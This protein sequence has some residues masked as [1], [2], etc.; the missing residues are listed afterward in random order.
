M[1]PAAVAD[2]TSAPPAT[3]TEWWRWSLLGA[4]VAYLVLLFV[5]W[6]Y[7]HWAY[8]ERSSVLHGWWRVLMA[9]GNVEWR[10]CLLVPF[11]AG[12][13]V[14]RSRA[15]LRSLPAEGSW[16]GA[17]V[18]VFAVFCYWFGYK[19]DTGYLGFAAL[20]ASVAGLILLLGGRAWMRAL[21]LPWAFLVFAWPFFPMDNLLAAR[22]KIPTAQIAA[23]ILALT[24]VD[25]VREGST[26]VSAADPGN[27]LALGQ[28][29][30]L[31]VSD[32]CSGMRSLY[33]L[34]MTGALFAILSLRD[35]WPRLILAV[36]T[37]PLAILGNVVRL[38]LLAYGSLLFGQEFAVGKQVDGR[39]VDSAFHMLAGFLLFGVALAGMFGLSALLEGRRR[40]KKKARVSGSGS[41]ASS[42]AAGPV[43]GSPVLRSALTVAAAVVAISLCWA[44]PTA[45]TLAEPGLRI[46][47]PAL[48]GEFPSEDVGMSGK[49]RRVFDPGVQLVRRQYFSPEGRSI[50]AT[51]V[52]SGTVKKTLHTPD[53]CLPDAGWNISGTEL[54]PVTLADGRQITAS[55]MRIFREVPT[56]DGRM[57]RLRALHLY[58]YH[59]SHGTST[60]SYDMHN[61]ISYRDAI[62]RNLNHRW[63]QVSFYTMVPATG[64]GMGDLE[65]EL[66]A[67]EELVRL[68]GEVAS[69]FV[70]E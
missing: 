30:R 7:Q 15:A 40:G 51:L 9:D 67:Q 5:V 23:Q 14:Y 21:F 57:I 48:V 28:K 20:Q 64:S 39:Q 66:K 2:T 46:E 52:L 62:F 32:S 56:E 38:L 70:K 41:A 25:V 54:V 29:F 19:V 35:R 16:W 13:L 55:L 36:S 34:I 69:S 60:P 12:W 6:P 53:V 43:T 26:I 42:A 68:A 11:V 22:L 1:N 44:S 27:A 45:A 10:F 58:W 18:L 37:V 8:E 63:S 47:L 50:Q 3:R 24:G 49:E 59:G 4:G 61:F 33:A 65:A 17:P 31:D